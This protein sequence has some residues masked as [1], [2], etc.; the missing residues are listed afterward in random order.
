METAGITR[1][2]KIRFTPLHVLGGHYQLGPFLKY[3]DSVN[4]VGKIRLRIE[5][6]KSIK[7]RV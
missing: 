1:L 4:T 5:E 7:E 3:L 2:I 6:L